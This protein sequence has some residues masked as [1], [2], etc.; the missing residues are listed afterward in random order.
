[1]KKTKYF[2]L[3]LLLGS[4]TSC[5]KE[6]FLKDELLANNSVEFLYSSPQGIANAVVGLYALNRE[7]YQRDWFNGAIP[8][9]LQAKSDLS[10]GVDGEISLFSNCFWGCGIDDDYGTEAAYGYFWGHNYRI[11]DITNNIISGG[12]LLLAEGNTDPTLKRNLSEA[13]TFRAHA[14]FTLYRLFKNIYIKTE[15]TTPDTAFE[16]PQSNSS[17]EEIFTLIREDLDFA[18]ENLSYS[19]MEFGRWTKAA[20]DHVRAKVEMWDQNYAKAAE[21]VDDILANSPHSLVPVNQVFQGDLQHSE[22]LFAVNFK[23]N[24]IGGGAWHQ[25]NWQTVAHYAAVPGLV[26]SIEN[27]GDGFGFITLNPYAVAL[28]NENAND[29]RIGNY[30]IFEYLYNDEKTLPTNKNIGDPLDLYKNVADGDDFFMYFKRQ[31]PGVIKFFDDSVDPTDRMHFKNI[32]VYRLAETYLIGAEAHLESG[33]TA[34][35]RTYL[36]AVRERAGVQPIATPSLERIL[37]ERAR[38]LAFEGQRWYSLKRRGLLF[39]YLMDHMNSDLLNSYYARNH[40]NPKEVYQPHMVNLPIPQGV[41]DLLGSSYPQNE[42][43]FKK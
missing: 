26:Q 18:S 29:Q 2:F 33:N 37:E 19:T 17:K 10:A 14:Y 12:E 8:L 40:V 43:Y 23:K 6:D 36:N 28:L 27:G 41:L 21:I 7:P 42:G 9:I 1:M 25:L 3:I 15:P 13:K 20:V 22:T 39:D 4:I 38:E 24:A 32:M 5:Y 31:S 34:K 35:A 11:I 30:Y 16:R